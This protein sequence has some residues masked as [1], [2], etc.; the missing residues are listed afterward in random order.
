MSLQVRVISLFLSFWMFM[1]STGFSLSL[2]YCGDKLENWSVLTNAEACEHHS[3]MEMDC[4]KQETKQKSCCDK[5]VK[6][7][8]ISD[9]CCKSSTKQALLKEDFN[10]TQ[11]SFSVPVFITLITLFVIPSQLNS[12]LTFEGYYKNSKESPPIII[13]DIPVFIQSFL[14]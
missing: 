5:E 9:N 6:Q 13:E 4:H 2:H 1:V 8:E 3:E 14:I 7:V 10:L 12:N 11:F